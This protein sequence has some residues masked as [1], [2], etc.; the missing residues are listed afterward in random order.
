MSLL[1]KYFAVLTGLFVFVIYLLTLAPSVLQIDAGELTAVQVLAGVAH[2]T[3]YPLFTFIGH[4]FSLLPLPFTKIYQMNLL[5]ALWCSIAVGVF[6]YT[7]K[8]ILDNI[9]FFVKQKVKKSAISKKAK[10]SKNEPVLKNNPGISYQVPEVVTFISAISAGLILAFSRTFWFQSTSVEVY[11]L[12]LVLITLIILALLKAYT[13][14]EE[15]IKL[16]Y[17]WMIFALVLAL[18]FSNHMTTLLIIPAAAYLYFNK[19]GFRKDIFKGIGL[20]LL[21]FFPLLVLIYSY[22]PLRASA[23]PLVNWG[24]PIDLERILRHVSGKQYQVWLFSSTE[25]AKKQLTYFFESLPLEFTITLLL[26]IAGLIITWAK[27]RKFFIFNL[28]V[29]LFTVLYS[30]NYDINDIDSYFLL[31][32]ISLSFFAMFAVVEVFRFVSERKLPVYAG[33]AAVSVIIAIHFYINFSV[34]DQ[35]KTY[36]FEDY[37]KSVISSTMP[38]SLIISYQWDDLISPAY[39]FQF[40][41]G[42]RKD[43]T[44]IDKELLRRS[45]YYNQ[46][47]KSDPNVLQGLRYEVNAFIEALKPFE[48]SEN[49]DAN[50]LE[51][52]YRTI[53]SKLI[54]ENYGKKNIYIAPELVENEMQKGEFAMPEGYSLIPDNFL[55]RVVKNQKYTEAKAPDFTIRFPEKRNKYIDMMESI[56]GNMLTRRAFYEF[57]NNQPEKAKRYINKIRKEYPQVNIPQELLPLAD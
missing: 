5:A 49:F 7:C 12:H 48:R 33:M 18:G 25:S 47:N 10:K 23:D 4:L 15:D 26:V 51:S 6:V 13:R 1:K 41:E 38:N 28:I 11:S 43:V 16:K 14:K 54:S 45:W 50:L 34:V 22:L 42:F 55:F 32:F 36:A 9:G 57:Q 21:L 3:G 53:L 37:S 39:Y 46:I 31:A 29:F 20:M 24:N 19:F 8:F 44:I 56:T 2:P 52:L 27:A 40:V 35:S 30:I 17:S